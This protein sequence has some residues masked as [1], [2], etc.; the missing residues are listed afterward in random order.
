[1]WFVIGIV[2]GACGGY[3]LG[4]LLTRGSVLDDISEIERQMLDNDRRHDEVQG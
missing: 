4:A 1:M 2:I 3:I